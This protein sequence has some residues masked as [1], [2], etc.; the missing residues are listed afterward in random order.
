MC[1]QSNP[2]LQIKI[3]NLSTEEYEMNDFHIT[4]EHNAFL[5]QAII[6]EFSDGFINFLTNPIITY[7]DIE[8][9][10][11]EKLKAIYGL[12]DM[13]QEQVIREEMDIKQ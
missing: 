10:E 11:D 5:V 2:Q 12:L 4:L 6:Y 1:S 3:K 7:E 9:K 8:D 13:I